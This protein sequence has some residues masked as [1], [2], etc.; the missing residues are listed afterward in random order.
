MEGG[1][2]LAGAGLVDE[3][4][5]YEVMTREASFMRMLVPL[6]M[7]RVIDTYW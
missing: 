2:W 6:S 7:E 4:R 3:L 1:V 5:D